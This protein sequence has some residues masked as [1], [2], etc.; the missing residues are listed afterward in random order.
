MGANTFVP[1]IVGGLGFENTFYLIA[2]IQF[3]SWVSIYFSYPDL[4]VDNK[5]K[6]RMTGYPGLPK[7][8]LTLRVNRTTTA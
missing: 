7:H 8:E 5:S 4:V 6:W 3:I 2:G 1:D